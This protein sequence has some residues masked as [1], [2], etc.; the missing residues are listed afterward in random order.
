MKS[1]QM[2]GQIV[3]FYSYKGGTGRTMALANVAC[4]LAQRTGGMKSILAIDWDL[5]A[6]G[7]HL[8]FS[9]LLA[10]ENTNVAAESSLNDHEGLIDLFT[11]I[12][13]RIETRNTG[14]VQRG[15]SQPEEEAT[16]LLQHIDFDR[17]VISTAVPGLYLLKAGR[18]DAKYARRVNSFQW[19]AL[20]KR[21]PWLF[22]SLAEFLTGRYDYVLIDSRTGRTDTSN[23]CT[24]LMPQKLVVVFTPNRQSLTGIEDLIKE[25]TAY[26]RRSDDFRTLLVYPLASRIEN[27]E[28]ERRKQWRFGDE[29]SGIIGYQSRFEQVF[30]ETYELPQCDL[31]GYFDGVQVDYVPAYAYGEELAVL[32]ER[33]TDISSLHFRFTVFCDW[34][35]SGLPPWE[36]RTVVSERERT[37]ARQEEV[38]RQPPVSSRQGYPRTTSDVIEQAISENKISQRLLLS[39]AILFITLGLSILVWAAGKAQPIVA[40]LGVLTVSLSW[41]VLTSILRTRRENL[42]IRLLEAVLNRADTAE[43]AAD[44]LSQFFKESME[45]RTSKGGKSPK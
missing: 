9:G 14:S 21:S 42:S 35:T 2:P 36:L 8:F 25:A 18:F 34:I 16:A 27:S 7:L 19:E 38:R 32:T 26:R 23:I 24:M 11:L 10:K 44:A 43:A 13:E 39:S 29:G 12:R 40:I 5:E 28:L 6:P 31:A 41:P 37:L 20:Y 15:N 1:A 3:T 30:K 4:L 45:L 17:F 33:S 22:Q